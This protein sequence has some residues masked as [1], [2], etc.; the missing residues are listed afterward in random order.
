M[1]TSAR[2]L[3]VAG[4]VV[5]GL[6]LGACSSSPTSPVARTGGPTSSATSPRSSSSVATSSAARPA[7]HRVEAVVRTVR[8][9]L[10]AWAAQGPSAA[11][12][13]LVADERTT[14]DQ[15]APRLASGTIRSYRL[16]RWQGPRA[17]T[18]LVSL[19]LRFTG[20]P[21]AWNRGLNDRFVTVHRTGHSGYLLE[22]ATGP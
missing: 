16:Y 7:R 5:V 2:V 11:S 22:L 19:D 4:L 21:L 14:S 13:Y 10:H 6:A 1:S 9:Y 20:S 17:F 18:L 12:R 8:R 15:G 3:V